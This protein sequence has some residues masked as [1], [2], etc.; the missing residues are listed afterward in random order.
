MKKYLFGILAIVAIG[1]SSFTTKKAHKPLVTK[2][3]FMKAATG[4]QRIE[5]GYD[6]PS[7]TDAKERS[8]LNGST[9][10]NT[11]R[12]DETDHSR[13][14]YGSDGSSYV[15]SFF[16]TSYDDNSDTDDS[17]GISLQ[18]ALT[19]IYNQFSSTGVYPTSLDVETDGV[20]GSPVSITTITKADAAL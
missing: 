19:A 9:F 12:W 15:N 7:V 4:Y 20:P 6:A 13:T 2:T 5:P 11:A 3:F 16:L 1:V 18:Q 14:A 8:V 10:T 17:D